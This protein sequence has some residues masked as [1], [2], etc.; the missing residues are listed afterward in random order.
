MRA[1]LRFEQE[2]CPDYLARRVID[3][4]LRED[5]RE[6]VSRGAMMPGDAEVLREA[7]LDSA[8]EDSWLRIDHLGGTLWLAVGP[9]RFMQ[10]WRLRALPALWLQSG[11]TKYLFGLSEI[12]AC[13]REQ[14]DNETQSLHLAF[15]EEC[16]VAAEHRALCEAERSRW[17]AARDEEPAGWPQ[18]AKSLVRHDRLAAFHDHPFYPTARAKLGFSTEDV[19]AYAPEFQ[20]A[21]E[22]NWLAVPKTR[23]EGTRLPGSIRPDFE[24]LG[25]NSSLSA[26]HELLPVHPALWQDG[27]EQFLA[28]ADLT[29]SVIRAPRTFLK[30]LPTLSVR[31][32]T[33]LAC[34]TLHLK[35]PLAIR[36]LGASNI[37]TI[38]P[39]TIVDGHIVQTILRDVARELPGLSERL[40]LTDE[41]SGATAFGQSFLGFILRRYPDQLDEE[42]VTPVAALAAP[43]SGGQLVAETL[44]DRFFQ[45]DVDAFFQSYLDLVLP[46][47]LSLWLKYG[48]ALESNQQN[49][50]LLFSDG[51][52]RLMLKD[53]DAARIRSSVLLQARP[54]LASRIAAIRDRRIVV[55]HDL[56]L[57][58]MFIT[59]TLQL[60]I[61]VL[62]EA[63]HMAGRADRE[64]LYGLVRA[65]IAVCLDRL[66]SEHVDVR[67][68][69]RHLLEAERLPLKYLLRAASLESKAQ[70]GTAD[71]NKFY[72][73]T[74]PNFLRL[75]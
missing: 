65:T 45:G 26:D 25:L 4:F 37:R 33:P 1:S 70:T 6:C 59:I 50:L 72:G 16:A 47:H 44:A 34:P 39:S 31:T 68:A 30:V 14:L 54:D 56:P 53:N 29:G 58:Q 36:T 12:L 62:V 18:W 74:A 52:M 71:V 66:A 15:A 7:K 35:L 49:S 73:V 38:K 46:L 22:L 57:A 8:P 51:P 32:V 3:A 5:V 28:Q 9:G 48:I 40:L 10:D 17:F 43:E 23:Y 75:A 42:T 13:F 11:K 20:P 64:S 21:F 55:D 27:L 63:L 67:S 69:Q 41:E 60:N 2:D 24:E 19:R 61:A